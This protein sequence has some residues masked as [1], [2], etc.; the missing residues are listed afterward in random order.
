MYRAHDA[1]RRLIIP[2]IPKNLQTSDVIR[3]QKFPDFSNN[4]SKNDTTRE[5]APFRTIRVLA[6]AFSSKI[7]AKLFHYKYLT[8]T[9]LQ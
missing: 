6:A 2:N 9:K 8:S 7:P 3:H 4:F 1:G 5:M